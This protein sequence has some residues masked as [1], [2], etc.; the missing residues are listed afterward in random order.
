MSLGPSV[1]RITRFS[2]SPR[3]SLDH[4]LGFS[5][6][7]QGSD[8]QCLRAVNEAI[9]RYVLVDSVSEPAVTRA[10]TDRGRTGVRERG[11]VDPAGASK[12]PGPT[13]IC[14]S[15]EHGLDDRFL[16]RDFGG[17]DP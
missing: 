9:D 12:S 17:R 2:Q 14:P 4:A 16:C 7:A 8:R 5:A 6:E 13:D 10:E 11:A 1:V 15:G 3:R